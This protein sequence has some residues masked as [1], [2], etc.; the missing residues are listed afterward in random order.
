MKSY[1]KRKV[2]AHN[3][4]VAGS[5]PGGSKKKYLEMRELQK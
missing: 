4:G 1:K 5:S 2:P 3:Q